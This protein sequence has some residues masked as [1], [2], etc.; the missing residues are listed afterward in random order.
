MSNY[1][2]GLLHYGTIANLENFS[3][4][5]SKLS[6]SSAFRENVTMLHC[7]DTNTHKNT[8]EVLV[9]S[10]HFD[11]HP[12]RCSYKTLCPNQLGQ[13]CTKNVRCKVGA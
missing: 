8:H 2:F 11:L 7:H 4:F 1:I 9:N 10:I 3:T 6:A 5:G 13:D 12:L